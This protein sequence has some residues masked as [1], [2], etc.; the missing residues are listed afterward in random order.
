MRLLESIL[1]QAA[2]G[3]CGSGIAV[4]PGV[5]G[6]G[7]SSCPAAANIE[8]RTGT[9]RIAR[10][11][12]DA[13][14]PGRARFRFRRFTQDA[15]DADRRPRGGQ[16]DCVERVATARLVLAVAVGAYRKTRK[17]APFIETRKEK[18]EE[19]SALKG[20]FKQYEPIYIVADERDLVLVIA[21]AGARR[22][23]A[24]QSAAASV[25]P[26]ETIAPP[27]SQATLCQTRQ[28]TS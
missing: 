27:V 26:V 9:A 3:C 17:E 10:H 11:H 15:L 23:P 22:R 13:L 7:L 18:G 19:Y 6:A 2:R 28:Y 16:L 12:G 14:C 1:P 20:F 5:D 24:N 21:P 25:T 4:E 8:G